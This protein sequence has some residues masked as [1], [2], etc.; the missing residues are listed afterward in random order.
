MQYTILDTRY[1]HYCFGVHLVPQFPQNIIA[2]GTKA[3]HTTHA[4]PLA[5]L[6]PAMLIVPMDAILIESIDIVPID[7]VPIDISVPSL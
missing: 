4:G 2:A 6:I 5:L 3:P 7:I 1:R